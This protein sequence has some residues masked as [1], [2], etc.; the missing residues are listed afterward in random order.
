MINLQRQAI[1]KHLDSSSYYWFQVLTKCQS[2]PQWFGNRKPT[3]PPNPNEPVKRSDMAPITAFTQ[4]RSKLKAFQF[5]EPN[6]ASLPKEKA[7]ADM[8]ES[9]ENVR[10]DQDIAANQMNPPPC[11]SSQKSSTKNSRECPQTPNGRL[12]LSQLLANGDDA[13]QLLNVTPVERV[14]WEN[15]PADTGSSDSGPPQRKRKRAQSS[16]S[17]SSQNFSSKKLDL[18]AL[19]EAFRTPKAD[20]GDDLW[21]RYSLNTNDKRS[22]PFDKMHMPHTY[23]SSSP[24]TPGPITHARDSGGLRRAFSCIDWPTSAAKRRKLGYESPEQINARD[25]LSV[26]KSLRSGAT[27][28]MSRFSMLVDRLHDGLTGPSEHQETVPEALKSSPSASVQKV[29]KARNLQRYGSRG[30]VEEV[31]DALSQTAVGDS[32]KSDTLVAEDGLALDPIAGSSQYDDEDLDL[33]MIESLA[34]GATKEDYS[35]NPTLFDLPEPDKQA[36]TV[37]Q[38]AAAPDTADEPSETIPARVLAPKDEFDDEDEEDI[39][40]ADIESVFAKFDALPLPK[41]MVSNENNLYQQ[42][43]HEQQKLT[44]EREPQNA[45]KDA[46]EVAINIISDDEDEFGNDSDFEEVAVELEVGSKILLQ[47]NSHMGAA[48]RTLNLY[49]AHD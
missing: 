29:D 34:E 1:P 28:K 9:K 11:P 36:R 4:S 45:I 30:P 35:S 14:L 38:V 48:V 7:P 33:E 37:T 42:D 40:A 31:A 41:P 47:N 6:R 46:K 17:T 19:Q 22:P 43:S 26:E 20:I 25:R 5:H 21:A 2:R 3:A 10:P 23:H 8:E 49:R 24:Q 44:S 16:S 27:L 18:K 12:P 32:D 15:S 13:A 39:T